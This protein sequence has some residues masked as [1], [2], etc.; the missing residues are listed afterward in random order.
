MEKIGSYNTYNSVYGQ[1]RTAKDGAASKTKDTR[2][3]KGAA[4]SNTVSLSNN[5]KKLLKDLQKDYGNMDFMIADYETDQEA[6]SYLSRGTGEYSVLL[7]PEELEKMAA[8]EDYKKQNLQTLDDAVS[9]LDDMKKQLGDKGD[10]VKRIGIAIDGDGKISYFA[11]LEKTT[12]KQRERID[13]QRESHKEEAAEAK[14]KAEKEK[15][16]G[17]A[18]SAGGPQPFGSVKRTMVYGSSVEELAKGIRNVD[19]NKVREEGYNP[20][21]NHFDITT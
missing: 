20:S 8:D 11:E 5:A 3:T 21:G 18:G 13:Q 9:K 7:T 16:E 4:K 10:D 2:E 6:A 14:K 19:W 17:L 12:E 1:N 15:L